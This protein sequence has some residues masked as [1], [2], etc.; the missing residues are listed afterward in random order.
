MKK[1]FKELDDKNDPE[2]PV[3]METCTAKGMVLTT[4][5]LKIFALFNNGLSCGS[6]YEMRCD[7]DPK[8]CLPGSIIVTA[9]NFC[10]PNYA[11]S[12][13]NGGWCNPPLQHFDLAE[14]IFLQI[15]QYKVGIVPVSFRR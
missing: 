6:C 12:N 7:S 9:T 3:V 11:L 5:A 4:A 15:A 8:W 13:S 1:V 10:P 14:P 2:G